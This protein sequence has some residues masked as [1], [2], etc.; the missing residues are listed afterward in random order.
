MY[1]CF[2]NGLK[3]APRQEL[4]VVAGS[5]RFWHTTRSWSLGPWHLGF[6]MYNKVYNVLIICFGFVP[7]IVGQTFSFLF[8]RANLLGIGSV[9]QILGPVVTEI[10]MIWNSPPYSIFMLG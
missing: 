5:G 1:M 4:T 3:R 7:V 6:I 9:N 2:F 8:C 10:G